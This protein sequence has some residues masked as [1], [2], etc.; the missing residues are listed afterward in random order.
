M[1]LCPRPRRSLR[2]CNSVGQAGCSRSGPRDA[3]HVHFGSLPSVMKPGATTTRRL[4]RQL[5]ACGATVSYDPDIRSA[6]FGERTVGLAAVEE[7]VALKPPGQGQRGGPPMAVPRRFGAR[8]RRPLARTGPASPLWP[9]RPRAPDCCRR[10]RVCRPGPRSSCRR[11]TGSFLL[12]GRPGTG[13]GIPGWSRAGLLC[14]GSCRAVLACRRV[15]AVLRATVPVS[16]G[17][18]RI[19]ARGGMGSPVPGP[20]AWPEQCIA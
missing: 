16:A 5:R 6:L 19:G 7:C 1:D 3:L 10:V 2:Q 12:A 18:D 11:G 8:E 20:P 15:S 4:M 9:G 17:S 13:A 14:A